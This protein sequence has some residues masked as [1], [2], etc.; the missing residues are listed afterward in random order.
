[1]FEKND[2]PYLFFSCGRWE[3]YHQ[4]TDTFEKLNYLK[5]A[6][7]KDAL[8]ALIRA[9]AEDE[10][11]TESYDSTNDELYFLRKNVLPGLG[12]K[13]DSFTTREDINQ[14]VKTILSEFNL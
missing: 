13:N 5:M 9:T 1:M 6:I 3:H 11:R 12:M 10:P 2:D 8:L 4:A 14:L 7:F